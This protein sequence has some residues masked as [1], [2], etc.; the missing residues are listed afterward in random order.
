M[1]KKRDWLAVIQEKSL[2]DK[3]T[4]L[5]INDIPLV[6]IIDVKQSYMCKFQC[7]CGIHYEK[8]IRSIL[9]KRGSGM[10]CET[11]IAKNKQTKTKNTT[12][13][14]YGV[15]HISRSKEI[16]AKQKA[17]NLDKYG[18]E[19]TFQSKEVQD[20][21]KTS[22]LMNYGVE[23]PGQSK[24][25]KAKIKATCIDRYGCENP[26]QV[27]EVKTKIKAT[28]L[29]I[30]GV[31][32]PSQ[33]ED[34][35]DKKK[36]TCLVNYGVEHPTQSKEI[37]D[38][39]KATCLDTYGFEH[40][41]QSEEIRDK[42]KAT[43]ILH[44]GVDHPMKNKDFFDNHQKLSFMRKEHTFKTGEIVLC[45]GYESVMLKHLENNMDYKAEDYTWN[46]EQFIY[47]LDGI[48]HR[49]YPDIPFM[50]H[51]LIIEIKSTWTFV[52]DLKR[53]WLKAWAVIDQGYNF[54]I[55]ICSATDI[56]QVITKEEI[57]V[58]RQLYNIIQ[59]WK[60]NMSY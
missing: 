41:V 10:F 60:L 34:I 7:V 15:D 5:L 57:L 8:N 26:F 50:K 22:L 12:L 24:E 49:Y 9:L 3:A 55:V 20:K 48:A 13:A 40:P 39:R 30:M 53:I 47:M 54:E 52:K 51:N 37:Q 18:V 2:I 36:A 44:Y 32:N 14:K 42:I 35:K 19:Y 56:L 23:H 1:P 38:R 46:G 25:I 31:E 17:T 4:I 11:C 27:E 21:I 16:Q 43:C 28:N 29:E 58:K 59:V 45:Q 33:F 6:N